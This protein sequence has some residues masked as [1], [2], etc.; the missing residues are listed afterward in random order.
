[1]PESRYRSPI[2]AISYRIFASL[3]TA[4][5]VYAISRD[6]RLSLGAGGLNTLVKLVLYFVHERVWSRIPLGQ[7]KAV[8]EIRKTY[9]EL[10]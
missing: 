6:V 9:Q 2:K 3:S 4:L 1:L 8:P 10:L 7:E 5:T